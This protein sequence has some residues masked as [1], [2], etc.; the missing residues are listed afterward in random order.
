[1]RLRLTPQ[2]TTFFDLLADSARHLVAGADLLGR[3]LGAERPERKALA[4]ELRDAEG[5]L[6]AH[7]T[8]KMLVGA[9]LQPMSAAVREL[10]AGALPPKFLA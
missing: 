10:G 2:N 8:S 7:A 4:A 9:H 6:L 3:L 5:R 1:M